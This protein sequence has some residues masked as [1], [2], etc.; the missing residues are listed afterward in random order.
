MI[1]KSFGLVLTAV[2]TMGLAACNNNDKN[3]LNDQDT[4]V[5]MNNDIRNNTPYMDVRN[6][7][8]NGIDH[9]GPLTEDYTN[10]DNNDS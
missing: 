9:N 7:R 5:G 1:K 8:D 10:N 3:D 6:G 2:L 4:H